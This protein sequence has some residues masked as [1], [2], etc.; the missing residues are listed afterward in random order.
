MTALLPRRQAFHLVNLSRGEPA[1]RRPAPS[2]SARP[3]PCAARA[4]SCRCGTGP[5]AS[6]ASGAV[7]SRPT[8]LRCA[9][10]G[11]PPRANMAAPCPSSIASGRD[12]R[13]PVTPGEGTGPPRRPAP[14]ATPCPACEQSGWHSRCP[15][16]RYR[17][18]PVATRPRRAA[19]VSRRPPRS[20]IWG[21]PCQADADG[22]RRAD[23][24]QRARP[25]PADIDARRPGSWLTAGSSRAWPIQAGTA[26]RRRPVSRSRRAA[27]SGGDHGERD[28]R[29]SG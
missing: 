10:D 29:P 23:G 13:Q 15:E 28:T 14:R 9:A 18:R 1:V 2:L 20:R 16:T 24:T 19:T 4:W 25:R 12:P 26:A 7:S 6:T 5:S 27:R 21:R 22:G 3:A 8:G 11:S 17:R